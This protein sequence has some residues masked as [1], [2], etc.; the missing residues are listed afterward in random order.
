MFASHWRMGGSE[1]FAEPLH[2]AG[3]VEYTEQDQHQAHREFHRQADACWNGQAKQDDGR[4]DDED[5]QGVA[6]SPREI[7]WPEWQVRSS[8]AHPNSE[9]KHQENEAYLI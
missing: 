8:I 6:A 1:L 2:R 5:G 3:E 4:A 9:L 7:Q